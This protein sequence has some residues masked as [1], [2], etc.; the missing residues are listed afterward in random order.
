GSNG[1]MWDGSIR[2]LKV[3][4]VFRLMHSVGRGAQMIHA[5]FW[6]HVI[7]LWIILTKFIF[8]THWLACIFFWVS[9][10]WEELDEDS[11][12][13]QYHLEGMSIRTQYLRSVYLSL[14]LTTGIGNTPV[15]PI[16]DSEVIVLGMGMFTGAVFWAY[17]VGVMF[18]VI[19]GINKSTNEYHDAMDQ[20][21]RHR[22]IDEDTI[23]G[24]LSPNLQLKLRRYLCRDIVTSV[25]I[26]RSTP[27]PFIDDIVSRLRPKFVST[28]EVVCTQVSGPPGRADWGAQ[29]T[30]RCPLPSPSHRTELPDTLDQYRRSLECASSA[31]ACIV[32]LGLAMRL[33][34]VHALLQ[35]AAFSDLLQCVYA[36]PCDSFGTP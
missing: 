17:G 10:V 2:L 8:I 36:Y 22:F 35:A 16:H 18:D 3:L 5:R 20:L 19:S 29:G 33:C 1:R 27:D 26:F 21:N 9:V 34:L 23:L 13:A 4:R 30:L 28:A 6:G 31:D 32:C 11:W 24:Y 15:A 14:T 7:R 25:P 12:A